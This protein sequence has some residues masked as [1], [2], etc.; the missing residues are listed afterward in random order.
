MVMNTADARHQ[1]RLRLT[2]A[3]ILRDWSQQ[4]VADRIGTTFVN[5]SRWERG[6]TKPNPY[7]RRKLCLLFAKTAQELDLEP[8]PETKS[9]LPPAAAPS[10]AGSNQPVYDT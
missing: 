10:M 1:P 4:E 7:F 8:T 3:R 6:I 2:E 9:A 5:V